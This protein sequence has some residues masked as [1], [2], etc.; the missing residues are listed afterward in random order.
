[1][2]LPRDIE[3]LADMES[4]GIFIEGVEGPSVDDGNSGLDGGRGVV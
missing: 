3:S 2:N 1:M 4:F